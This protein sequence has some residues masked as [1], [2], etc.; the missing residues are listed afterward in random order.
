MLISIGAQ[1]ALVPIYLTFWSPSIF[2]LWLTTISLITLFHI[3]DT[4]HQQFVGFEFLKVGHENLDRLAMILWAAIPMALGIAIL[5][6]LVVVVLVRLGLFEW[7][8]QADGESALLPFL[9]DAGFVLVLAIFVFSLFGSIGGIL[10]RC[11]APLG[12]YPRMAWW[13]AFFALGNAL[14]P[15]GVVMAGG[16]LRP[17]GIGIAVWTALYNLLVYADMIRLIVRS[18]L[19]YRRPDLRL[20]I[21]NLWRSQVLVGTAVLS[22][23]R[24]TGT[25]IALAPL[26][27]AAQLAAFA[28]IRT[29][30]NVALQGLSTIT[31]PLMPE[32]MRYLRERDQERVEGGFALI[33]S[34]LVAIMAPAVVI[35]QVIVEPLFSMWTRNQIVFEPLL[36]ALLSLGV[37]VFAWSQPAMAVVTG[38]N[39][40]RPQL[41]VGLVA[42]VITIGGLFLVVPLFGITGAGFALLLAEGLA[43]TLF[44]LVA[45]RWLAENRMAWPERSSRL[46]LLS[47]GLTAAILF[48]GVALP[49]QRFLI[50]GVGLI[51]LALNAGAYW[52]SL[53]QMIR[54][55]AKHLASPILRVRRVS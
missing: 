19:G 33:W 22:M 6:I 8:F 2:G 24:T 43:A 14:V 50:L 9:P 37:L 51:A 40:L 53:P 29:G 4:G 39:L 52:R 38:N 20:G 36:F 10:V 17:A 54:D 25:R 18:G 13:G 16:G 3:V 5:Q 49:E 27:G 12:Y 46:A 55:R 23:V 7:L 45:A 26:T 35:L 21:A 41:F 44:S 30:A 15:A 32:L 34:A 47:V 11:L 42:A 31:N 1:I 48:G 28:T